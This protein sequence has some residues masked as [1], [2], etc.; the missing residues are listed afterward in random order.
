MLVEKHAGHKMYLY[1]SQYESIMGSEPSPTFDE[2]TVPWAS[3]KPARIVLDATVCLIMGVCAVDR[4]LMQ[5]CNRAVETKNQIVEKLESLHKK[6]L[7][8]SGLGLCRSWVGIVCV[9]VYVRV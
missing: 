3:E 4:K 1:K 6:G 9:R 5:N 7:Q 2:L 8:V